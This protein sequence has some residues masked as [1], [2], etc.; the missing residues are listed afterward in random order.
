MTQYLFQL[1]ITLNKELIKHSLLWRILSECAI[2][3]RFIDHIHLAE[4][5]TYPVS[6]GAQNNARP[7][8]KGSDIRRKKILQPHLSS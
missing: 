6:S 7:I 3:M 1:V 2:L 4:V 5:S 8:P